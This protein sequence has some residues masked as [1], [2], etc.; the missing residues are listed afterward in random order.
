M[1]RAMTNI[2]LAIVKH[3]LRRRRLYLVWWSLGIIVLI[4]LTVLAYGSVK[5]QAAEL[6]KA[7]GNLS[8]NIGSFVGTSDMF[9]P[10]GYLNS[11]LYFITLP[12]LFILLSVTLSGSLM[13][14]EERHGTM[15]L[16]LS[17]PVGRG[18]L[19]VAKAL[20]GTVVVALL[21]IVAA[22]ITII[23]GAAV[24]LGVSA[25]HILLATTWMVLFS[26]AFGAIAFMLY[27]AS[28]LTRK[29]AAAVAIL[30]SFGG[31]ILSS[32]GGMVHG[33]EWPAKLLPYHYYNPGDILHGHISAGL[34]IYVAAM[35][36]VA[37]AI[38]L[39]GFRR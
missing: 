2:M 34:I 23:C 27:A 11:Q 32:L 29:A 7:M 36:V 37:I 26:G 1:E 20:A 22:V 18:R 19:L 3:E 14:K 33:L 17:R 9:S 35:Y 6:N 13:S 31:Y 16:L 4:A 12:I 30:L 10:V 24:H 38:A 28:Q 15:E 8:S 25:G 21:G 39:I 5:D